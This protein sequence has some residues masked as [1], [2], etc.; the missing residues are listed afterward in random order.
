M[1]DSNS[2]SRIG[3]PERPNLT[4]D[5][6][7]EPAKKRKPRGKPRKKPRPEPSGK[8]DDDDAESGHVDIR[9]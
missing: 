3:P 1:A 8:T 5:V 2:I 7:R 9:A 4:H 6:K